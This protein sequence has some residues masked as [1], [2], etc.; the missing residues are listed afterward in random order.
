MTKTEERLLKALQNLRRV[1]NQYLDEQGDWEGEKEHI[2]CCYI[3][4]ADAPYY[5]I[6]GGTR[7]TDVSFRKYGRKWERS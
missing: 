2:S 7:N 6:F 3:G 1:F 4:E 5:N